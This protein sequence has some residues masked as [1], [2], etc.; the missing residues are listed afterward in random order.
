[1]VLTR[2]VDRVGEDTAVGDSG[3]VALQARWNQSWTG[4]ICGS[5]QTIHRPEFKGSVLTAKRGFGGGEK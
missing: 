2:P 1:M 4:G 5:S 3:E